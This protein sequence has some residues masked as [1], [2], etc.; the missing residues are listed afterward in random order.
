MVEREIPFP[1]L[2]EDN[3]AY[4]DQSAQALEYYKIT[5]QGV[6]FSLS[7]SYFLSPSGKGTGAFQ[8]GNINALSSSSKIMVEWVTWID[9][10]YLEVE[11]SKESVLTPQLQGYSVPLNYD[12]S[13]YGTYIFPLFSIKLPTANITFQIQN[14]SSL[15]AIKGT[16]K[17]VGFSYSIEK[18]SAKP[19]KYTVISYLQGGA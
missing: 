4:F 2:A 14:S 10:K 6:P 9:N 5:R 11:W 7:A 3:I 16:F 12:T 19:D 15:I 13:P 18:L 17:I 1:L 8:L